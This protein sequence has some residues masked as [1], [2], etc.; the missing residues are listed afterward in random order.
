MLSLT[1]KHFFAV[2][3]IFVN[4]THKP[5]WKTATSFVI[6]RM[7]LKMKAFKLTIRAPGFFMNWRS[8]CGSPWYSCSAPIRDASP[9]TAWGAAQPLSPLL[10]FPCRHPARQRPRPCPLQEGL[11]GQAEELLETKGYGQ[12]PGKVKYVTAGGLVVMLR[13]IE[14]SLPRRLWCSGS[15]FGERPTSMTSTIT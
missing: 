9:S 5:S 2:G 11:W 4:M 8:W 10:V 7:H 3:L 13:P 14:G 1:L 12:G 6:K 15:S